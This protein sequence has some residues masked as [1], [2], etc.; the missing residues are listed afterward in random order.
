[1]Q[2]GMGGLMQVVE[3]LPSKLKALRST[4]STTKPIKMK[5]ERKEKRSGV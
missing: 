5:K 4:R 3:P 1:M 2:K